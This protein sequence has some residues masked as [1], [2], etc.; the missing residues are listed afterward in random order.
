MQDMIDISLFD[1]FNSNE[2]ITR[3]GHEKRRNSIM[4][5]FLSNLPINIIYF[6]KYLEPMETNSTL[7]IFAIIAALGLVTVVAVDIMMN[8]D[9]KSAVAWHTQFASK[10]ECTNFFKASGN[11][12]SEAQLICNKVIPH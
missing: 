12:T 6:V 2:G 5:S 7:V 3:N 1:I 9:I 8:I 4:G 11:T 10:K